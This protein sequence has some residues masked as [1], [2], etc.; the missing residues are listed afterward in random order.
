MV[1]NSIIATA[2]VTCMV[3][4][5]LYL[6][7]LDCGFVTIDDPD[8]ILNNP[9]IKNLDWNSVRSSLFGAHVG[10]WMPLTWISFTVEHYFW[11]LNPLGYH[12]TN[13]LLHGAN[14]ALVVMIADRLMQ[15][16]FAAQRSRSPWPYCG[17][18]LLAGL[19]FGIH[20]L[21]VES[22]A[23][24]SE[25]KDVLNGLFSLASLYCYLGYARK[26]EVGEGGGGDYLCAF[27]LM[28][29]SLMAKSVSVVLP[30]LMFL[31]D[32]YPLRRVRPGRVVPL[33]VEKAPFL[34]AS[35]AMALITL[36]FT[37]EAGYLV[38]YAA[39]PFSQRL[40]VSGNALL[41]YVRL[42]FMP[43]AIG[44]LHLIPDPIPTM[45][46][47]K[48][49]IVVVLAAAVFY[50]RRKWPLP[51]A[52]FAGFVIPL[53]PVLAFFQNGDQSYASRFTYLP[54][55]LPSI[56]VAASV[57]AAAET[58][59]KQIRAGVVIV[60]A[61]VL[62]L[63]AVGTVRLIGIWHDSE[64]LLTRA[65]VLEPSA[66]LYKERGRYYHETGRY[67][68]AA[69]DYTTA[70]NS[71]VGG[72][73]EY[74]YNLYAF[75]GEALRAAGRRAE[76]VQDFSRAIDISPRPVYFRLRGETLQEMGRV[77]EAEDDL[78]RAGPTATPLEW[79]WNAPRE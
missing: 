72:F 10:W 77:R 71:A 26:R 62:M 34:A 55:V 12:L 16:R 70:I 57:L 8:Y 53:L 7:A 6:P 39:F 60:A 52:A 64:T 43:V 47:Y 32:C 5:F 21:R 74:V 78:R 29:L 66:M 1:K 46:G 67:D 69:A 73:R 30:L 75:R 31:L 45:Y 14:A 41:E 76:A 42:F 18:L 38:S 3:V 48:T 15:E 79:Y 50:N 17:V 49:G 25:R 56:A 68:A 13:I 11:G 23:W 20:P 51:A 59:Q 24:A 54:S 9:L 37:A 40:V 65:I 19:L 33:L 4:A 2:V 58:V 61:L 63:Y 36:H 22:V 28:M 27:L 35:A 44:P